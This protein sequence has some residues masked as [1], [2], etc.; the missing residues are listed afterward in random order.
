MEDSVCNGTTFSTNRQ[1][2]MEGGIPQRLFE[3]L[4]AE[5]LAVGQA[6]RERQG[7][8][9]AIDNPVRIRKLDEMTGGDGPRELQTVP[10]RLEHS[11]RGRSVPTA[12]R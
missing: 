3:G 4:Q 9:A 6:P 12:G 7:P 2:L 10:Q 11:P 5:G 1:R 8:D